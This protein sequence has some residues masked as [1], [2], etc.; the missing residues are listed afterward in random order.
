MRISRDLRP[1]VDAA[2]KRGW[3]IEPTKIGHFKL[4]HPDGGLVFCPSSNSDG[5]HGMKN[6]K[7]DLR[8]A[9]KSR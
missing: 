9:E 4:T 8:R 1:V 5:W 2:R 6:L 7:A 3:I